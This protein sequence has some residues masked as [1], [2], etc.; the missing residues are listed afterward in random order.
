MSRQ[1]DVDILARGTGVEAEIQAFRGP[2]GDKGD[3]GDTGP[4]GPQGPRGEPGPQ[5]E[6]GKAFTY[7]DFTVQQLKSLT[8]PRGEK[9][10]AFTYADFTDEQLSALRGPAGP[11]GEK[12]DPGERGEAAEVTFEMLTQ[13]AIS[14]L[15]GV[16]APLFGG[17]ATPSLPVESAE[18]NEGWL[19]QKEGEESSETVSLPHSANMQDGTSA[20]MFRGKAT[21]VRQ[22]TLED[23]ARLALVIGS[24]GMRARILLDGEEK[25]THATPFQ[26]FAVELGAVQGGTHTLSVELDNTAAE[27]SIPAAGNFSFCNG[28]DR[29]VGLLRFPGTHFGFGSLG[30][31]RM[32]VDA[33]ADGETVIYTRVCAAEPGTTLR[34]IIR[35]GEGVIRAEK[36]RI[37]PAAAQRDEQ[38]VFLLKNPSLWQ[39]REGAPLYTA[40]ATLTGMDGT[41]IDRVNT[42]F[43]F[44]H[45]EV[46]LGDGFWLNGKKLNLHG[47]NYH[48]DCAGYGSAVP[49][50]RLLADLAEME[51]LGVNVVRMA[52]YPA[53][54]D[55]LDYMDEHGICCYME[56]PFVG[57]FNDSEAYRACVRTAAREMTE[58][59]R[60]HPCIRFWGLS[61]DVTRGTDGTLESYDK[62]AFDAFLAQLYEQVKQLDPE[63]LVGFATDRH[64]PSYLNLGTDLAGLNTYLG[65]KED[66]DIAGANAYYLASCGTDQ[67]V[68]LAVTEYGAGA[69]I[70]QHQEDPEQTLRGGTGLTGGD[71]HPEEYASY[72]HEKSLA[73]FKTREDI[74]FYMLFEMYDDASSGREEGGQTGI[75]DKGLV[76]RDR[77][78]RKD[79]FYL[80]KAAWSQ[81]P[82]CHIAQRRFSMRPHSTMRPKVYSNCESVALY[83]GG[84]LVQTMLRGEAEGPVFEF[85]AVALTPGQEN[86]LRAV[87]VGEDG[88]QQAEDT[89]VFTTQALAI[90]EQPQDTQA[91]DGERVTFT[92][93]AVGNGLTYR[94]QYA[95]QQGAEFADVPDGTERT[96]SLT[97]D[98]QMDGNRYRCT[99][100]DEDGKSVISREAKLSILPFEGQDGAW[101]L[102]NSVGYV[103]LESYGTDYTM[104]L[105]L[106]SLEGIAPTEETEPAAALVSCKSNQDTT[107]YSVAS[108]GVSNT[109]AGEAPRYWFYSHNLGSSAQIRSGVER[110][111][112][113]D[114]YGTTITSLPVSQ[115]SSLGAP[116]L[117][118]NPEG[119]K[120]PG[121][122]TEAFPFTDRTGVV[123]AHHGYLYINATQDTHAGKDEALETFA[124]GDALAAALEQGRIHAATS[125]AKLRHL[126]F[127][128]NRKLNTREEVLANRGT[129]EIDIR[130]DLH[131]R[132]FNAGTS[133]KLVYTQ[134]TGGDS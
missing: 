31:R 103:P 54:H 104:M 75:H 98:A 80:Y 108:L 124:T 129:A 119:L 101:T 5:G 97:V 95:I 116:V 96:L 51:E 131:G 45:G 28:L 68:V 74:A 24:A 21:Y 105:E 4:A 125:G 27:G 50:T 29:G 110:K 89:A 76:T 22:V 84:V 18:L 86:T 133:G 123:C 117:L 56:I 132:P 48:Q 13:D 1:M 30:T 25:G 72:V 41:L 34:V 93:Q 121:S 69:N 49:R 77:Q 37:L 14:G 32:R 94:W 44:A 122:G 26:A 100:C 115:L 83:V 23:T 87:G 78:V 99:V 62:E 79:A 107:G 11:K 61:S 15:Y 111:A 90:Q 112:I 130:F 63:R 3:K 65:W 60:N 19:F 36:E 6:Q 55:V 81:A 47:V 35:D 39:G 88:R 53:S 106:E 57:I 128:A 7:E 20:N 17:Q 85:E 92:I 8:G 71:W 9:G 33:K 102:T 109:M 40:E 91:Y 16:F 67:G 82:V 12:G 113:V 43:G 38:A 2:K 134:G 46:W 114:P 127:F 58:E 126:I 42:R 59:Y 66:D 70:H 52:H 120:K 64:E 10:D 118:L 73:F